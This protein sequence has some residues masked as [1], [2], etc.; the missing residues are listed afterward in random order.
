MSKETR[1]A[2]KWL[3]RELERG[4]Y[5]SHLVET[6]RGAPDDLPIMLL[7]AD[8]ENIKNE[9]AQMRLPLSS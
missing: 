3:R 1:I 4:A 6:V 8:I 2:R 9:M 7:S 5:W